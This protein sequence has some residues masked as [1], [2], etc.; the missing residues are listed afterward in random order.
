MPDPKAP[1]TLASFAHEIEA[2]ALVNELKANGIDARATGETIAGFRAEAPATVSIVVPM[3]QLDGA[4]RIMERLQEAPRDVDWS[5][6]D[7][8]NVNDDL[9][10]TTPTNGYGRTFGR[11]LLAAIALIFVYQLL[12][13]LSS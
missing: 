5:N 8:G 7:V 6:V 4:Q 1:V 13:I 11:I 2:S 12:L 9:V 10:D 3:E